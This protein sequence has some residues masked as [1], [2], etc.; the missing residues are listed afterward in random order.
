M[1][2]DRSISTTARTFS[3][4]HLRSAVKG[5]FIVSGDA[6]YDTARTVF[7]GGIDRHPAAIVKV[8]DAHDVAQVVNVARE[9]GM[10]LAI[11]SGG[12]SASGHSVSEG[13]IVIDLSA[14]RGMDIDVEGRTAWIETGLTAGE[15][16]TALGEHGLAVGFGDTGSV[17][18]G[19]ITVGG[20][21]GFLV[22]KFGLTIDDLLAAEVVT[23]DGQILQV[24]SS[25]HP[26]L[27]WA[28][29]GGGGN[30]G[31]VTRVQ[32]R[33]HELPRIVGGMLF[34]PATPDIVRRF[35]ELAEVAPEELSTIANV[36]AA[37]PPMPFIPPEAQGKPILMAILVYA[38]DAEAGEAVIAPFRA[39]AAPLADMVRPITY[40]EMYMPDPE[41]YH[42]VG[43]TRTLFIDSFGPRE[44]DVIFEHFAR[45]SAQMTVAQIRVLGGAMARV[46]MD[47]TAFAHR[48]RRILVNLAGLYGT[49]A[50]KAKHEAWVTAFMEALRQDSTGAYV[51]FVG[52]E[53]GGRI[54]EAYPGTTWD[55][56]RA[57]KSRYDPDNLFRLNQNIPPVVPA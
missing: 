35:V 32:F 24:D 20:G 44:A 36:L 15:V 55:R 16:T 17:G 37:A 29:R 8:S 30:F 21:V 51:N 39:L 26:D 12:H 50:D 56:L 28:I 45:S 2:A 33:L 9:T 31:V 54:R 42:P 47:A 4:P 19:G 3:I 40:P 25:H 52:D 22:R 10:E 13:G 27:F 14:M 43:A 1:T 11:R 34:L 38:G 46:P 7:I 57:V 53:G 48:N 6:D 23:A 18:V 49:P 5:R 41:D